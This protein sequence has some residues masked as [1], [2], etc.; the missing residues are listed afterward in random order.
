MAYEKEIKQAKKIGDDWI[1][2]G[3]SYKGQ[4]NLIKKE[5]LALEKGSLKAIQKAVTR[6]APDLKQHLSE[7]ET[8]KERFKMFYAE[9]T[10][11]IKKF[12]TW[13]LAEPRQSMAVISQK[14]NLGDEKSEKYQAVRAGIKTQLTDVATVLAEVQRAWRSDLEM[15]LKNHMDE[16]ETL[17]EIINDD[18]EKNEGFLNQLDKAIDRYASE[19]KDAYISLKLDVITRDVEDLMKGE[20]AKKDKTIIEQKYQVARQRLQVIPQL[21]AQIRKNYGRVVKSVPDGFVDSPLANGAKAKLEKV[22]DE[23][24]KEMTYATKVCE[25]AVKQFQ[26][27]LEKLQAK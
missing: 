4:F 14:L 18:T 15:A 7:V 17:E 27:L 24:E 21:V 16:V 9:G 2:E 1:E 23:S 8:I 3:E 13:A 20:M 6:N 5:H 10:R 26:K 25:S 19:C 22:K 12:D 11:L